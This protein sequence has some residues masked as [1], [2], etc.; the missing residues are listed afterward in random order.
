MSSNVST[1]HKLIYWILSVIFL[2][3]AYVQLNDP[4]PVIWFSIYLMV[5]VF[6]GFSNFYRVPNI[7]LYIAV[8]GLLIF[9]VFHFNYFFDWIRSNDK[10]EL[11]GEM[12]YDKPYIEG[13]KEFLGLFLAIGSLLYLLRSKHD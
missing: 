1:R 2:M 3:F 12:V 10:S 9:L 4:D 8:L 6:F 11:F 13:T 7:L 5:A